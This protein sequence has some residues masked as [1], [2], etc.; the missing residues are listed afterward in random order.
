MGVLVETTVSFPVAT[1]LVVF[2]YL[3]G[4]VPFALIL[5]RLHGVDVRKVGSGNPGATNLSRALGRRWGLTCF[6]LD[7]FKGL[8]PVLLVGLPLVARSG[9]EGLRR[10]HAQMACALAA[11]LG[12]VFPVYLGFRGG[13]GVATSFGGV[14]G[15]SPWAALGAGAI[16]VLFYLMTRIVAVAS[17]AAALTFPITTY[18]F[19]RAEPSEVATPM[20][21]MALG[22]GL[23]III[24]HQSNLRRLIRGEET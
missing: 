1:G 7:F 4:S 20:V 24:R 12:H 5:G 18:I 21:L 6:A 16:W 8:A 15:I 23:L 11:I 10:E 3:L 17:M 2:S 9:E 22:V 13:K 14:T 19:F